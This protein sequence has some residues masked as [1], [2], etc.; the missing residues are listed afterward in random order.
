MTDIPSMSF[1]GMCS[2]KHEHKLP[3]LCNQTRRLRQLKHAHK[4]TNPTINS[5]E[6]NQ[7]EHLAKGFLQKI[8]SFLHPKLPLYP[9]VP[10]GDPWS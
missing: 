1:R 6:S 7:L 3:D 4:G 8:L 2:V 5:L 10:Q 9:D